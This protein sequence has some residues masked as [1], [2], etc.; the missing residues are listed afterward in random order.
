MKRSDTDPQTPVPTAARCRAVFDRVP[1]AVPA[2]DCDV[3]GNGRWRVWQYAGTKI[4]APILGNGD[5]LAAFAGPCRYPQFWV[6][7]NDFWQMESAANW[8][9]FH[10]NAAARFDPPVCLGSPRPIG[11]LV[12]DIPALENTSFRAEQDFFTATTAAVFTWPDGAVCHMDSYVAATENILIVSLV[13]ER[14]LSL[15]YEFRFP[16]E[17]GLGCDLGIDFT[18]RRASSSD[19][20]SGTFAGLLGGMPLQVKSER[21][22]VISG[23]REFSDHTD[24]TVRAGFAASCLSCHSLSMTIPAG[25]RRVFVLPVRTLGQVSRPLE[26]A[27]SRARWISASDIAEL[28][29]QHLGWWRSYWSVSDVSLDDPVIEQRY[30]LSQYMMGSLS[31][32]PDYPPD[33]FGICTFDRPAWNGNY[34]I[35]YNHQTPYLGL[36]VSGHFEQADPHDAPYLDLLDITREMSLRLLGHSGAYYPLGLGPHGMVSEALL[37]HMKSP[38][39]HGA[40]NMLLRYSLTLDEAYGRRVY[41]FLLSVADFW[42]QELVLRGDGYHIVGDGMHERV[43]ADV[44]RHG[45]PEDPVNTLGYLKT[46]FTSLSELSED[47]GLDEARR[48]RWRDIAGQL[49]PWPAGTI[50]EIENNP[51][52]WAEADVPL[53][54]LVPEEWLDR[55]VFYDEGKGG[56]W[57]LHFPGNIMHIYPGGAI[58]L[59][60]NPEELETARNTIHIHSLME[61]ALAKRLQKEQHATDASGIVGDFNVPAGEDADPH[62]YKTGAWNSM[63]LNALFFPAAVRVGYDPEIIWA[64][65][66]DRLVHRGLPNGF[67]RQNPHGIENL[68]LVP[69]TVQEMMLQSH[70]RLL[71]I[72]PVWPRR[73]HPDAAFRCLRACGAFEVSAAL[74]SG[75]IAE[76]KITSLKGRALT[77]ENPWPGRRIR[78]VCEQTG[79]ERLSDGAIFRTDTFAGETLLLTPAPPGKE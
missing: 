52:L 12:F 61:N 9:F 4:D 37:L 27:E 69:V 68:S 24:M 10:D 58:G 76:V 60:S 19:S 30:Y 50:R 21:D 20:L 74:R 56:R 5:L 44:A 40:L 55:P 78:A 33:I 48:P 8:E 7:T 15:R 77:L 71:R 14:E 17:T 2:G 1:G 32:N 59:S 63:N 42:E 34:K 35:N 41:P 38:A 54:E 72:F 16:D 45:L 25:E 57:S 36:P 39:V 47:L 18:G 73:Q 49:A 31:R 23:F 65:L 53:S 11:R 66:K 79:A 46:F 26:Y 51:T 22:G 3:S 6:S 67:F 75:E 70:D 29:E 28:R 13:S 62:F 64:E 43:S